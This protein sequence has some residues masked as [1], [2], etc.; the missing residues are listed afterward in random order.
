MGD[1]N[2][3]RY[4]SRRQEP[5]GAVSILSELPPV[6]RFAGRDLAEAGFRVD[7]HAPLKLIL[8]AQRGHAFHVLENI[9]RT[10]LR[11]VVVT[12]NHVPEYLDDLWEMRPDILLAGR[13]VDED[14]AGTLR[15]VLG[16]VPEGKR[17]RQT[18]WGVSPLNRNERLVLRYVAS[19]WS[20]KAIAGQLGLS[21]QSVSN[22]L[23]HIYDKL[24]LENRN[25]VALARYYLGVK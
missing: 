9:D 12:W 19:A 10:G 16:R 7:P 1:N 11:L 15:E 13:E 25:H 14:L 21:E 17:H 5:C 3:L 20:H 8:D 24:G 22:V 6:T 23:S 18:P 2:L 4:P